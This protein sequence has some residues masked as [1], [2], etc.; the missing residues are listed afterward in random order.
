MT[1][2]AALRPGLLAL[3]AA[4]GGCASDFSLKTVPTDGDDGVADAGAP[5][6]DDGVGD[7][8]GEGTRPR[9]DGFYDIDRGPQGKLPTDR[10]DGTGE[11]PGEDPAADDDPPDEDDCADTSDLV[12]VIARDDAALYLFDPEDLSFTRLGAL[13]C[14]GGT[15]PESMSVARD[16]VA[17]VRYSDDAVYEVDLAT[18]DCARTDYSD[19][20]TDFGSF[21]MGY[22]TDSAETWRD[23]LYVANDERLARVD[24]GSWDLE[25]LGRMDSQ[26]E[27]TGNAAGELWAFLPLER[28]AELVQL[29]KDDASALETI[30]LPGFPSA[31]DIDTFA[32]ATWGGDFYLFVREYGMGSTTDV[33]RVTA[34]GDMTVEAADVGFDVVGAG[35][36]TCAPTG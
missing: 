5:L 36:S 11:D 6:D 15:N 9:G 14:S 35:V 26:S 16:G 31:S 23:A 20:A 25:V 1:L 27:L 18:L 4:A 13:R 8:D 32:F 24:M 21:G 17:Y 22:A 10:D 34:G 19:R 7:D 28:P 12:Y 3:L 30:R 33:Y 2:S 29:D